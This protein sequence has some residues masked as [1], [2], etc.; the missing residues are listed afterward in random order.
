[1]TVRPQHLKIAGAMGAAALTVGSIAAAS[2]ALAADHDLTYAC[3]GTPIPLGNVSSTLNPGAIPAKLIAGQSVKRTMTLTVHLNQTQTGIAQ[4][5]GTS[6][7]GK[8]TAKGAV[9]FKLTIP[10]TAIPS[11]PGAT[12]DATATGPGTITATSAGSFKVNAG[13]IKATLNLTGGAGGPVTATQNCTAPSGA[14]KTLGTVKVAKDTTKSKVSGKV[15][16]KKATVTDKVTSKNGLA[17]TGKVSFSLKK[18]SK[19][20]K[21]SG[22]IKKGVAK[23][24]ETLTSGKWS[25]TATY[26]GDKNLKGSTGKGSV[27]VK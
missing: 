10:T 8:I 22:T 25:V 19:T 14:S 2:P 1:M 7:S 5:A 13:P 15:K 4:A 6:V 16:G 17:A 12:M 24:S 11:T 26:K 3:S 20:V 21:A 18:G 27:T 23:I 9:A